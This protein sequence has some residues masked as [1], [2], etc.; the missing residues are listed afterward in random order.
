MCQEHHEGAKL[1]C[2][3][4]ESSPAKE[5]RFDLYRALLLYYSFSEES[6]VMKRFCFEAGSVLPRKDTYPLLVMGI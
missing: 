3:I 4:H 6:A 5:R 1:S 2:W